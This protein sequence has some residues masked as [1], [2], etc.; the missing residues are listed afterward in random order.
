MGDA[1]WF[2]WRSCSSKVR[3]LTRREASKIAKRIPKKRGL[4]ARAYACSFCVF[5][6]VGH[7]TKPRHTYR[8]E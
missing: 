6:H 3:Y 4:R 1:E 2:R 5:F 7:G 8:D